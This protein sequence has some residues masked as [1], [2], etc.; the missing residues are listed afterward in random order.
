MT[1]IL[2]FS[3]FLS[4]GGELPVLAEGYKIEAAGEAIDIQVGHLVP[5]VADWNGDGLKDLIV[6]Q[7]TGGKIRLYLN[8]GSD[9]E[10]V[11]GDF[12]FLKAGG[13]E[14]SLPAG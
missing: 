6:G 11:F 3:L 10:P 9:S 5:C 2:F 8:K 13:S 12:E 1:A 4:S 7:F 14:I